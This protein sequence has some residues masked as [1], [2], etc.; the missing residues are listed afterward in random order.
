VLHTNLR[1]GETSRTRRGDRA[2]AATQAG[3]EHA[4]GHSHGP[5]PR[6]HWEGLTLLT[7]MG[8]AP[9]SRRWVLLGVGVTVIVVLGLWVLNR[10]QDGDAL[11]NVRDA[12]LDKYAMTQLPEEEGFDMGD[13][14][15][16]KT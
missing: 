15:L 10:P 13:G 11:A 5:V 2:Q 6:D 16:V 3:L 12:L 14:W 8:Q 9:Q 1:E 7:E 4:P